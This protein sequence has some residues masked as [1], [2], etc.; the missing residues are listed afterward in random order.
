MMH[1]ELLGCLLDLMENP[2]TMSHVSVWRGKDNMT[3]AHLLCQLWRD[4]ERRLDVQRDA[5]GAV[6]GTTPSSRHFATFVVI[7]SSHL[8]I[9]NNKQHLFTVQRT[10]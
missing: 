6:T 4:E 8:L 3:A 7:F 10:L 1:N 5:A 9:V 2:K